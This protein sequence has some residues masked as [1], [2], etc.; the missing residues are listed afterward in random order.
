[1][2]QYSF[3][4]KYNVS[5]VVDCNKRTFGGFDPQPGIAKQCFC[6][7]IGYEDYDCIEGEL[8]YWREQREVQSIETQ[9]T[10]QYE[11]TYTTITR[12]VT[13]SE[14]TQRRIQEEEER[15]TKETET[16]LK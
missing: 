5:G 15:F 2:W 6:D 1:M 9:S 16:R 8:A 11:T 4:V 10:T 3:A 7:D 13:I 12:T 14:E